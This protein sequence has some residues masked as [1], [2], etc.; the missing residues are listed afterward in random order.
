MQF[1]STEFKEEPQTRGV[2]LTLAATEYQEMNR[3]VEAK[4]R[5]LCTIEH[6]L[7]VHATVLEAYIIF[8]LMYT[9]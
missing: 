6:S 5:T 1:T 2:H 7:M 3:K 9:T 4:R 8:A